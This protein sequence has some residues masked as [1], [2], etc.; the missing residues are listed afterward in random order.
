MPL[1]VCSK[2]KVVDNTG[3]GDYWP[4]HQ[5]PLCSECSPEI[6]AWHGLFPREKADNGQWEPEPRNPHFVRRKSSSQYVNRI[7]TE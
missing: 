6:G 4:R 7:S 1:F 2:C 3:C 5:A